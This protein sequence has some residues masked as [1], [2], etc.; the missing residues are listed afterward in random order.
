MHFQP[1]RV[2]LNGSLVG[3]GLSL[4]KISSIPILSLNFSLNYL[5]TP[6]SFGSMGIKGT[7][8]STPG[9][10]SSLPLMH[11]DPSDLEVIWLVKKCKIRFFFHFRSF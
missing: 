1:G 3:I 4:L 2:I 7:E 8:E 11:H 9:K 6:R 10:D 5:R